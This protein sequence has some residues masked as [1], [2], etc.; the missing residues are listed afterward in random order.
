[1][2][3]VEHLSGRKPKDGQPEFRFD[4]GADHEG[5]SV[6]KQFEY[7]D[8]VAHKVYLRS[9]GTTQWREWLELFDEVVDEHSVIVVK[10]LPTSQFV[11][12]KPNINPETDDAFQL[13]PQMPKLEDLKGWYLLVLGST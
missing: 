11:L 13:Q 5:F 7:M 2:T 9:K 3:L 4:F 6:K 8:Y 1:M 12:Q 10:H